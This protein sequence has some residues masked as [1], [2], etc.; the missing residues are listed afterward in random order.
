M[1]INH[2]ILTLIVFTPLLGAAVLAAIPERTG[3]RAHAIGALVISLLTFLFT[4]HLPFWFHYGAPAGTFQFEQSLSWIA[5]PSIRYHVGW[6]C[7]QA[8]SAP[9]ASSPHGR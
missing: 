1:D 3:S 5:S 2:N 8:F 9:S 4:L 6:S 7:S